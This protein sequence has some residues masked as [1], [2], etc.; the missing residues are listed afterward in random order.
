MAEVEIGGTTIKGGKLLLV[1]PL[2]GSLIG[3]LWGGFEFYKDY[4]DMKDKIQ[5][6]VAPDLSDYDKRIAIMESRMNEEISL[7]KE[8]MAVLKDEVKLIAGVNRDMKI[9]MKTDIRRIE[10]IVEDTESRVK[11]DSREFSRD[12]KDLRTDL[13]KKIK[14]ALENPL[15]NFNK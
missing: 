14:R 6:Y 15:T 8:E 10:K 9:D 2:L 5:S 1:L 7:F 12:M 4:M 11:Q 13:D 3:A